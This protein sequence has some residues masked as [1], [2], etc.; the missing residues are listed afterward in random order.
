VDVYLIPVGPDL[1]ALYC[2]SPD[3]PIAA[4]TEE[5]RSLWRKLTTRFHTVVNY[6]E[7]KRLDGSAGVDSS[8]GPHPRGWSAR[9]RATAIRWMAEKVAEQRLLWRLRRQQ[10][11][12]AVVPEDLPE[13]NARAA[14]RHNLRADLVR[15]RRWLVLDGLGFVVSGLVAVLPGPNLIAYYFAF[16]VVGHCYSVLGA[17]NGLG[18]VTWR[19]QPSRTLADLR[20]ALSLPASERRQRLRALSVELRL[21]HLVGFFERISVPGA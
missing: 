20:G 6:V 8:E 2:E 19:V 5:P 3:E 12:I 18:R 7:E 4:S 21:Q 16:R 11:V 13:E 14:I 10:E 9:V 17:R 15:H 1:Y